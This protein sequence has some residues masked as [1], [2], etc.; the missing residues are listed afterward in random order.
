[1]YRRFTISSR[2]L[3]HCQFL[4]TPQDLLAINLSPL[5]YSNNDLRFLQSCNVSA[6]KRFCHSIPWTHLCGP[7]KRCVTLCLDFITGR[8]ITDVCLTVFTSSTLPA[9]S[10][11]PAC[12]QLLS[13]SYLSLPCLFSKIFFAI[14]D[15]PSNN[16]VHS[17]SS[18]PLI[19]HPHRHHRRRYRRSMLHPRSP[20]IPL[21]RRTHLRSRPHI[22]RIRSRC[23]DWSKCTN[24]LEAN[25]PLG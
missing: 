8:L 7:R 21:Y 6:T 13:H 9:H 10:P 16:D 12:E 11:L 15:L 24:S 5:K 1:M 17:K 22:Q 20:Q 3:V 2:G 18:F 23:R 19:A 14:L 4:A 25:K